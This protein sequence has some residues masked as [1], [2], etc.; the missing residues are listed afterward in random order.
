MHS[1]PRRATTQQPR[2]AGAGGVEMRGALGRPLTGQPAAS[3]ARAHSTPVPMS[4]GCPRIARVSLPVAIA[5][6]LLALRRLL[7]RAGRH[8]V[9]G[10]EVMPRPTGGG[11]DEPGC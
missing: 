2:H 5:S 9:P 3:R 10:A 6:L 11:P 7:S 4:R 8:S 1:M